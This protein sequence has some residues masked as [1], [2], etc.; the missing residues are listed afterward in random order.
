VSNT[1]SSWQSNWGDPSPRPKYRGRLRQLIDLLSD[2]ECA[3][4]LSAVEDV[5]D[6]ERFWEGDSGL[7]YNEY[8]KL[9]FFRVGANAPTAGTFDHESFA[10]MFVTKG[11]PHAERWALPEPSG[12][13]VRLDMALR[14]RRSR[15]QYTG[16]PVDLATVSSILYYGCGVS[17]VVQAYGYERFPL[18]T[19][20]TH[21]GLQSPEVY[22]WAR[23]V[24]GLM[25]GIYHYEPRNHEL[26]ALKN[27][28]FAARLTDIAFG[29]GHVRDASVA[30][31]ITGVYDRLRWKYG[32]RAYRFLCMDAGFL[33][34]NIYLAC[35]GLGLAVCALSGFA[36]DAVEELLGVD[37]RQELAVLM[38]TVGVPTGGFTGD[39]NNSR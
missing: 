14:G 8:V 27:G 35:E 2:D 3:C 33:G 12:I 30:F 23:A 7:F 36:Q 21:G 32:E 28:D 19:F 26:E 31:L 22:L 15:R 24:T 18:R 20:P 16:G 9:R 5:V 4:L 6:G 34:E 17:A 39:G 11:Y 38:L 13:E 1:A 29:E 37:G 25:P 10:P